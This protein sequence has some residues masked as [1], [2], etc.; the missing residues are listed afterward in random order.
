VMALVA[1]RSN[2]PYYAPPQRREWLLTK[3]IRNY[4]HLTPVIPTMSSIKYHQIKEPDD[5]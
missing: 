5:S 1:N 3:L 4:R 2:L